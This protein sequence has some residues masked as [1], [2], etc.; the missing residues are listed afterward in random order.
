MQKYVLLNNNVNSGVNDGGAIFV[1]MHADE[2][3]S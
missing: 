3:L 2:R 1:I